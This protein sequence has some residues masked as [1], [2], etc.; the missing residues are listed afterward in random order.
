MIQQQKPS[1]SQGGAVSNECCAPVEPACI[2][3]GLETS[4][5]LPSYRIDAPT[6][7]PS[8]CFEVWTGDRRWGGLELRL[9]IAPLVVAMGDRVDEFTDADLERCIALGRIAEQAL[10]AR[11][12]HDCD[13]AVK[14]I[15]KTNPLEEDANAPRTAE[16]TQAAG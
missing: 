1:V 4:T 16:T 8:Y 11:S 3:I 9:L 7:Q 14:P 10:A 6:A 2:E 12:T 5:G 15:R 13:V